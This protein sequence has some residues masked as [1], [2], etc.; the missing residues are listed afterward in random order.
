MSSRRETNEPETEGDI[1]LESLD[2]SEFRTRSGS[3]KSSALPHHHVTDGLQWQ[4]ESCRTD[5]GEEVPIEPS[6]N[7][8]SSVGLDWNTVTIKATVTFPE[9][10]YKIVFPTEDDESKIDEEWTARLG[11]V[12]WCRQ[13]IL[14]DSSETKSVDSPGSHE[15]EIEIERENV[16]QSVKIEP[17]LVRAESDGSQSDYASAVGHRLAEGETWTLKTDLERSTTN[18]LHPETKNFSEDDDLPGDDHLVY[19]DFERDPPG[20]YLNGDHDR[21]IAALDSDS[22]QGWDAAVREVA[23]DMIEAEV[24]PQMILEAASEITE[25][26]GPETRWKQGVIEKFREKI[27]EEGTTYDEAIDLLYED[28]SSPE[29]LARLMH[30]IDDAVQTRNDAPSHLDKLL[31]LVDN[32]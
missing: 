12:Y 14:R 25:D 5:T 27:Y 23:Y 18:L 29:R 4:I 13:T 3:F 11:L 10:A 26:G 7:T 31:T 17:A 19:V 22:Y 8:I 2:P 30:D 9:W 16:H 32:R 15:L 24:W 21:I 6:T 20:V 28:V 1:N